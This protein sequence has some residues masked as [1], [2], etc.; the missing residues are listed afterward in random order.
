M[1]N[2]YYEDELGKL[3]TLASEFS[4]ANPTLAPMLAGASTDPDVERVLEGV[5]FLAG[6]ARQKLDDEFPEFVQE[7]ANLLFPHYLRPVPSTTMVAFAPRG[8]QMETVSIAAGTELCS[9]PVDG[10]ACSFRTTQA[11]EAYPVALQD[12]H[13]SGEVGVPPQLTLDFV[14]LGVDVSQLAL[15][16][17]RLFLSGGYSE[18]ARL[19]LLLCKYVQAVRLECAGR[20]I[21]LGPRCLRPSGFDTAL[22]D[23]PRNAFPG[24]R[25]LQEFF[26]QPEKFLFV[27]IE[28][29]EVL[30]GMGKVNCFRIRCQ[31][32]QLPSWVTEIK[33]DAFMLNVTPVINIFSRAA[34]PISHEH[35]VSEY[36]V[37]PEAQDRDHYRVFSVDQVIGYQQG[38]AEQRPYRSFGQIGE[39]GLLAK[40]TF[41]TAIRPSAIVAGTDTYLSL[42]YP[43]ED[44]L[45]SETLSI[46]LTCTNHNLPVGLKIGDICQPTA[47]TPDRM[48]FRN[49]R[50]LTAPLDPPLGE[51]LL[52]RLISHVSLNFL[53]LAEVGNLRALLGIYLFAES[54]EEKQDA[55]NRRRIDGIQSVEVTRDTR[56]VGRGSLMRGQ[57]IVLGCRPDHYAGPGDL[58]L[59]GS[60][61][62]RFLADY[63]PINSYTRVEVI[64][65][66]SGESFQWPPRLGNKALL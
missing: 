3:R 36:R 57:R 10:T 46:A 21:D 12:V 50:P 9:V 37:V 58:F 47:S 64:D 65:L 32:A 40:R 66:L 11:I 49:I 6:M 51:A 43:P 44:Q 8:A 1:L 55:A 48:A 14:T 59:F 22:L 31:M 61:V 24:Y 53:S 19:L 41:R 29:L 39:D 56:L 25:V 42:T 26:V 5:A 4:R 38:V 28:G 15:S 30:R 16:K 33:A 34:E 60:V 18:A 23:Y 62:E 35:R 52:W 45:L 13:L 27:D 17:L 54:N 2:R 63:A 7:I 20:E